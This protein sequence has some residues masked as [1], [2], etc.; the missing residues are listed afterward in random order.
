[1]TNSDFQPQVVTANRLTD[2]NVV[3]LADDGSWTRRIGS[4]QVGTDSEVLESLLHRAA[5][6]EAAQEIVGAYAI[7]VTP[8]GASVKPVKYKEVIRAFGPSSHTNFGLQ[9]SED[10]TT[11]YMNGV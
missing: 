2:G 3:Y 1:M 10:P 9:A 5:E 7:D 11:A 8:D 4:A 6:A